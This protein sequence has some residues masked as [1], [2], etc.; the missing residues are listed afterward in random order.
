M[1]EAPGSKENSDPHPVCVGDAGVAVSSW[2]SQVSVKA[3]SSKECLQ[4]TNSV[5]EFVSWGKMFHR[6]W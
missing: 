5:G 4:R 6:A 1:E 3:I 2:K